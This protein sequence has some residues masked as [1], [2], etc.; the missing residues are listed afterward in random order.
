MYRVLLCAR[1]L[2]RSKSDPYALAYFQHRDNYHRHVV[3]AVLESFF[4]DCPISRLGE[5]GGRGDDCHT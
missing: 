2:S 5:G 1:V 3:L 4:F